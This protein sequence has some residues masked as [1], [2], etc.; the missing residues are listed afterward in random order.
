MKKIFTIIGIIIWFNSAFSQQ[1]SDYF[2]EQTG[3]LWEYKVTP[4]D[5]LNNPV[6]S[7]A[8]FRIDTFAV[9]TNY[10]GRLANIIPTKMGP[11]ETILIQPYTDSLFISTQ[12]TNGFE[13]FS[14]SRL[15]EFLIELDSL[16]LDPN[17]SFVD[18]FTSLQDWYS[19]YRFAEPVNNEYTLISVDTTILTY[20]LRF[21]FEATRLQDETIQTV[22]GSFDCKKFFAKWQVSTFLGPFEVPLI[23]IE[24]SIWIAQDNWIVQ[25]IIP[26]KH[27]DLTLLGFGIVTIPGFETKLTDEIVKV[28]SDE[29]TPDKFVLEQNF[30]NPFNPSTR[31]SYSI[32]EHSFITLKVYDILG[33]EI[34]TLVNEEKPAGKYEIEFNANNFSSGI[35]FYRMTA[36]KLIETKKMILLK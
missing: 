15:E 20:E 33:N 17:F 6:N 23:W 7:E 14:I 2:P 25:D 5:S 32:A 8:F 16:G 35:Y 12:G 19:I 4:L 3:F 34:A 27:F 31:I 9:V 22:L 26:T 28:E 18:F 24:D 13:Y 1:A 10:E 36:G 30:P 21:K 11:L 29:S